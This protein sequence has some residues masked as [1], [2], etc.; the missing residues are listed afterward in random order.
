MQG[1]FWAL[2]PPLAAIILAIITK[3]VYVS[4]FFGILTGAIFY[5][6]F[7]MLKAI[8]TIFYAM[9]ESIYGKGTNIR[10]FIFLVLL[11]TIVVLVN[12]SGASIAFGE[13]A[14]K[15]IKTKRSA[16]LSTFAFALMLFIDDYFICLAT[17]NVMRPITDRNRVSRA[18]LAYIVDSTAVPICILAPLSSW[19][20]A[21]VSSLSE[22]GAAD[23]FQFF[24][25]TIPYN[26][27]AILTILM[28]FVTSAF[29][30][31]FSTMLKH[32]S[33]AK[34]G[35]LFTSKGEENFKEELIENPKGKVI[36]LI[37]PVATLIVACMF[38]LLYTG[39]IL[40]GATLFEAF[41]HC[42][43]SRGLLIGAFIS[44]IV[45]FILYIPRK[46]I[47]FKDFISSL[48]TGF[49]EM[50]SAIIILCMAWTLGSITEKYMKAGEFISSL[51]GNHTSSVIFI[52]V[53]M[54][55]LSIILSFSIGTS[56]GTFAMLIPI[57][58]PLF[59]ENSELLVITIAA[60]LAGSNCGDHISPIADTMIM[61]SAATRCNLINHFTTQIPYALLVAGISTVG[62]IIAALIKNPMI[63]LGCTILMLLLV[64]FGIK[65]KQKIAQKK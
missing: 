18:K 1:T 53:L 22:S 56:W 37:I 3:E 52:P 11:G 60:I 31:D 50:S 58:F 30:I 14:G 57:A 20:A 10:I 54:F 6:G 9:T 32:E 33:N 41:S 63:V 5:S 65:Y 44:L 59:T 45:T 16:L 4:L 29:N 39:G 46:I 48:P 51:V 26:L 49:K 15:R 19:S 28:V 43:S 42:E 64:L 61:S 7:D 12:K 17:G 40:N 25:K 35:D 62:Y 38:G 21:V 47:S 36:D 27:Y 23:G 24:L 13:W 2:L 8:D 34:N 55:I